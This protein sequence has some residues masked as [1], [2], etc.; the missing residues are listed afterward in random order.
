[1]DTKKYKKEMETAQNMSHNFGNLLEQLLGKLIKLPFKFI[2]LAG[3]FL[4]VSS[5]AFIYSLKDGF[6]KS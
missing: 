1:M 6:K 4:I 5:I 2:W 3:C